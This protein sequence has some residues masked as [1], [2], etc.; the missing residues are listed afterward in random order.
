MVKNMILN[1]KNIRSALVKKYSSNIDTEIWPEYM[2]QFDT[3][4]GRN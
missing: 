3:K 1:D 4:G 2:M